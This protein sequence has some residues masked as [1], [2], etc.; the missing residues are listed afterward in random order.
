MGTSDFRDE[1]EDKIGIISR[2]II[3]I[4]KFKKRKINDWEIKVSCS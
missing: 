3:D 1:D 4:Y 2:S